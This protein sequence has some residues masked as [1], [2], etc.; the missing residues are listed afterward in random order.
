MIAYHLKVP[1]ISAICIVI[2][3]PVL[4]GIVQNAVR[5]IPLGQTAGQRI[6]K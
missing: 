6:F 4:S 3:I 1:K 5:G 2:Y